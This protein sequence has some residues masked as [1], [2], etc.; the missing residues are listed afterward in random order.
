MTANARLVEHFFRHEYGRL[1]A[2]LSNRVGIG[3]LEAVED[4]VQS[5]LMKALETWTTGGLPDNP[6]AWLYKVALNQLMGDFRQSTNRR[7]TLEQL[8]SDLASTQAPDPT[9]LLPE[10]VNDDLLRMLFVCCDEA[11]P[12]DSQ[13]VLALKTLC[14]FSV[15]E[16]ALRLF[17]TEANIYKRL[18]RARSRLSEAPPRFDELTQ[19]HF[20]PRLAAVNRILYVF[21]TEGYLSSNASVAIRRE[22]CDEA[23]RLTSILAEH[24]IGQTPN[25]FSLLA[26]MHLHSA[27]LSA[28]QDSTGGLLLLE[29][30]DRSLW[31]QNA[32]QTGLEWLSKSAQ[33]DEFSR[34][35]AEASIAAEHCLAPSYEDTRWDKIAGSYL[36]LEKITAS[37]IHTLNR[38]VA[39]AQWKGP[40]EGL[41]VLDGF[42]P[43]SWLTK[44][45]L[46]PA[47]NADLHQRCG[48]TVIAERYRKQALDSAPTLAVKDLLRIRLG[49]RNANDTSNEP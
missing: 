49:P 41:C 15:R 5:A 6:T 22:I 36:L 39:V 42:T 19:E 40:S 24:R 29:N 33:G 28:R 44:S 31:D 13:L 43:P 16:I 37:P 21:F 3:H 47:V 23:L 45:Y 18:A 4:A 27:R 17:A 26:L 11:I 12:V 34:Y 7:K 10:E 20:S 30:Q 9:Y 35:H 8:A 14:G 25:T 48:N 46:W 2:I 32:I 1:V 38:A